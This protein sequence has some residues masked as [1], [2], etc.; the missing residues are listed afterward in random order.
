MRF[1]NSP[2]NQR[3]IYSFIIHC[4]Y[5]LIYKVTAITFTSYI[6]YMMVRYLVNCTVSIGCSQ[7]SHHTML[8]SILEEPA[9]FAPALAKLS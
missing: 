6:V 2:I 9:V 5:L 3:I 1:S 4:F 7:L 8:I